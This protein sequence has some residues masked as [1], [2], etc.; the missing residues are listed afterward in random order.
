MSRIGRKPVKIPEKVEA[1]VT[2]NTLS[3][4]GPLGALDYEFHPDI[5]VKVEDG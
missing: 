2:N 3:V 5:K 1:K 4:Q